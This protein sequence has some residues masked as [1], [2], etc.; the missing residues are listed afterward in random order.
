MNKVFVDARK[1]L[2]KLI[3]ISDML[4]IFSVVIMVVLQA[5]YIGG[6]IIDVFSTEFG[7]IL[8]IRLIISI[9]LLIV[10]FIF[11]CIEIE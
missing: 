6:N 7:E 11:L 5:S 9:I 10:T 8:I 1:N 3:I 2:M 4:V